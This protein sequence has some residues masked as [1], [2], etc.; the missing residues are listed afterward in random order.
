MHLIVVIAVLSLSEF[1]ARSVAIVHQII[2]PKKNYLPGTNASRSMQVSL[3]NGESCVV[4][5][6]WCYIDQARR[7]NCFVNDD[8]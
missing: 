7:T 5:R 4:S 1:N 2:C 3:I 8:L 6:V